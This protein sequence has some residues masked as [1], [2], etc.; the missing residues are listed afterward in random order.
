MY[1]PGR[2]LLVRGIFYALLT[3]LLPSHV[4]T[5]GKYMLCGWLEVTI[6]EVHKIFQFENDTGIIILLSLMINKIKRQWSLL[7]YGLGF[8]S[9]KPGQVNVCLFSCWMF[10]LGTLWI[11]GSSW[12]CIV[13]NLSSS[14]VFDLSTLYC[15]Q[16][17]LIFQTQSGKDR[18]CSLTICSRKAHLFCVLMKHLP[19]TLKRYDIIGL[20]VSFSLSSSSEVTDSLLFKGWRQCC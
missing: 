9:E 4:Q 3:I 19:L 2:I 13:V 7:L 18:H 15:S 14:L 12:V 16:R 8:A 6:V 11:R 17:S 10:P 20:A 1:E 5:C